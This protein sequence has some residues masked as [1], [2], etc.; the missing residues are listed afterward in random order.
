MS[1]TFNEN[2]ATVQD[3]ATV[4]D[5]EQLLGWALVTENP[6][7]DLRACTHVH[8]AVLQVMM[9]LEIPVLHAPEDPN[10]NRWL[11]AALLTPQGEMS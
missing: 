11:Q 10:F 9:A 8:A 5:A 6:Q 1:L 3:T 4:E 2:L 7:L